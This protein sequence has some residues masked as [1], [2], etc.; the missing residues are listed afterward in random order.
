MAVSKS[1]GEGA[2]E[3]GQITKMIEAPWRPHCSS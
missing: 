3:E 1:A 2:K